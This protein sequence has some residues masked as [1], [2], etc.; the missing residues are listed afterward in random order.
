MYNKAV[1]DN[2]LRVITST[3]P[4]SR[5]VCLAILAGAGSCYETKEEA[6]ISHFAEHLF[7]KGTERRPTS[8]EITQDIEGVG[9]I[10]NA[11][12]DKEVTI[13]WCKVAGPHF[14]IALDVLS[15]LL[16]NSRFDTKD[17]EKERQ[18]IIEEIHM[19]LDI[20]QQRV[21]MLIDELLWPEQP[22]GREVTGYKETVSSL[23]R[24]RLLDYV[25]RRYMPNNTVLS[26]AGN[27]QHEEAMAQIEPRF[28][29][30]PAGE[31]VTAYTTD[32]KQTKARLRIEPKDIEQAHLCLAVHG[33]SRSHPQRF[34][35]D[36]LN[37]VLG[38]GMSS[39][40]FM[41]IR[42]RR[43]LAYDIHSYTEHF[44]DSGSFGIYAGV[45]PAKT[46][47]ALA[48]ILEELSKIRH[49][50]ATSELTR[51]KEL[52]KGR[53]YLRFEDSQNVALWYGTQEILVRQILDVDD[54]ISIVDA[55]TIDELQEVAQKILTD[56]ELN[57]AVTG[58]V[59]KDSLLK[60]NTLR[61]LLKL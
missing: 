47:T 9:G 58:P 1:L 2:G 43:G 57:L 45:D 32:D 50:I 40:L 44:L 18:V 35:L 61:Q 29:K 41:E 48:A 22:L 21:N 23:T 46:E 19:N 33:F 5:S 39:R 8:R 26:I 53:L 6:G 54:V 14:S 7:F 49:G 27:I 42:E 56:S 38:G 10:I 52:S 4:H 15:D 12:T 16:L 51:A 37:T 55:I 28:D 20:P 59:K 34:T 13:F 60:E 31:L 25:G 30:W 11:G 36:L 3:M 17:V 24:E